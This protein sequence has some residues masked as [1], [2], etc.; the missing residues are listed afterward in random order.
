[1][2]KNLKLAYDEIYAKIKGLHAHE[3]QLAERA[4]KWVLVAL[5][6]INRKDFLLAV[7]QDPNGGEVRYHS[8][9]DEDLLLGLCCNLLVIDSQ[10]DVWRFSHLSVAEY[11]EEHQ[12]SANQ[13]HLDIGRICLYWLVD[14]AYLSAKYAVFG[15]YSESFPLGCYAHRHV[16]EHI[17]DRKEQADDRCLAVLLDRFLGTYEHPTQAFSHWIQ[18]SGYRITR[19]RHMYQ[20]I[21]GDG[22]IIM[23]HVICALGLHSVLHRWAER[24]LTRFKNLV[25]RVDALGE[26][27]L[28][29]AAY[30]GHTN[31][32][33]LLVELGVDP[34][35]LVE[36]QRESALNMAARAGHLET[37][38]MLLDVGAQVS[39]PT[40]NP[41]DSPLVPAVLSGNP[42]VIE[43]IVANGADP[44]LQIP[45]PYGSVLAEAATNK[46]ASMQMQTLLKAG[47]DVNMQLGR[48]SYGSA[49]AAAASLG[50]TDSAASLISHGA[51]IDLPLQWGK[52]GSALAAAAAYGVADTVHHLVSRG[53]NVN[54]PLENGCYGSA[55][56]TA[57]VHRNLGCVKALL[58]AGADV[59]QQVNNR[60]GSALIA[61]VKLCG[62]LGDPWP[63]ANS[64]IV[65]WLLLLGADAQ[66]SSPSV[67][68]RNALQ[69]LERLREQQWLRSTPRYED[70][71]KEVNH[72]LLTV[73]PDREE[74]LELLASS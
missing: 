69:V 67:G 24:D 26:S 56:V 18:Q 63:E 17:A 36:G 62:T 59:N 64:M 30:H 14:K 49:L 34:N 45:G 37:V 72:L 39:P 3:R 31:T 53:A 74:G 35:R 13:A 27:P 15:S 38:A 25:T 12:L 47:A 73:K 52:F 41:I 4:F 42:L 23:V 22:G 44:N 32:C 54:M 29:V 58:Q 6:P 61:A 16:F 68:D 50:S 21:E 7:S 20:S 66:C 19:R 9:V 8:E 1:M 11:L 43:R 65:R 5:E 28:G 48:D 60:Y 2:P 46:S 71:F 33:A 40:A 10:L 70:T 51:T 57:V 55:L